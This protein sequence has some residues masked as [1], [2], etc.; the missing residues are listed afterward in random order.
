MNYTNKAIKQ[1]AETVVVSDGKVGIGTTT[2]DQKLSVAGTVEST[3]GGFKFPDGSI[4]STSAVSD[5]ALKSANGYTR[6]P[7]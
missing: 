5:Q 4:Q 2:P 7:S 6:L 1:D 3:S